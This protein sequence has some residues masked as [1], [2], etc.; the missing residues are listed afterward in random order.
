MRFYLA[1]TTTSS[2][3]RTPVPGYV[4][5]A[6]RQIAATVLPVPA[7]TLRHET[8]FAPDRYVALLAWTNEPRH[9]WLPDPLT[10][11]TVDGETG[12]LGTTGYLTDHAD[13]DR[14]CTTSELGP[15]LDRAGGA[16]GLFRA[17]PSGLDA[18]T[19]ITRTDPVYHCESTGV[20]VVSN[21]ASL[22]HLVA[23]AAE[24]GP[25]GHL[26]PTPRYDIAP[27]QALVRH[28]FYL[29]DDTPFA[30]VTALPELSTLRIR[31]GRATVLRREPPR[32]APAPAPLSPLRGRRIAQLAESLVA[33]VEPLRKHP[34]GVS[35][36]L[37]GG[38]DSRL[39]AATLYAAGIPFRATTTGVDD[40]PDV[41]LAREICQRL[42]VRDHRVKA[43]DRDDSGSLLVEHPLPRTLRLVRMTEGMN[44]AFENVISPKAF[45]VEARISGSGG[46]VLRGGWLRDQSDLAKPALLGRLRTITQA[47]APLMT[48]E[49][50]AAA[51][52]LFDEFSTAH[53]HD[54]VRA[55]DELYLR[56]RTGR[57]LVGS[58]TATLSGFCM[59]HPFLDHRVHWQAMRVSPEWRR[60]EEVVYKLIR[61]LAPPIARMPIANHPWRFDDRR[62]YNP[63]HRRARRSRPV[64]RAGSAA[65]AFHW[66]RD[67]SGDYVAAMRERILDTPDVFRLTD[68]RATERILDQDPI[69]R[70]NQIWSLYTIA[71][72]LSGEWLSADP[73]ESDVERIRVPI[74]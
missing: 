47:Q 61:R 16:F 31:D 71:V 26:P 32:P 49:A 44:S 13:L 42:G 68:R 53:A 48:D 66:R 64:R 72:L 15:A 43:P 30:G 17:L 20:H 2:G 25:D 34:D 50:N 22:G 69:T 45:A 39:I 1:L 57:W 3:R 62:V 33:S 46:E 51:Q 56:F 9:E 58:R 40:H 8:W 12:V 70:P 41:E 7:A 23:R 36:A 5:E 27:M 4:I 73:R 65:G 37:S 19:S 29:T 6:A 14:L 38:R 59:Y 11:V 74:R 24:E 60:S 18:L 52:A 55:L 54:L 35:M 67:L 10:S 21:R 63:L 28:G